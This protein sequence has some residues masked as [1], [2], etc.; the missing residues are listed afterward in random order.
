[1]CQT[2]A[3]SALLA[4]AALS[5]CAAPGPVGGPPRVREDRIV[6]RIDPGERRT[7]DGGIRRWIHE[8]AAQVA[9]IYG[10]FPF[11]P[12]EAKVEIVPRGGG[13]DPV[14][15]GQAIGRGEPVVRLLLRSDVDDASLSRD[16]VA[17]HELFHLAMPPIP[18]DDAWLSEG[19]AT[20]YGEI[21]RA[22]A[23]LQTEEEAWTE[24][25]QGFER[26]RRQRMGHTL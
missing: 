3:V 22:R 23:G 19:W 26:G 14:V 13:K 25:L 21:L 17:V 2:R 16:W 15:F 4:L 24:L 12:V 18:R 9:S 10:E 7:T 11:V 8:S 6:V 1:M 20:W 5:A